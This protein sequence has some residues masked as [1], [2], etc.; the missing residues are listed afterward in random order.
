MNAHLDFRTANMTSKGQVLIPKDVR[1]RTGLVPGQ[2]VRVGVNEKG[3]AVVLPCADE[4]L[5]ERRERLLA[6]IDALTGTWKHLGTTEEI[7]L[8]LRGDEPFPP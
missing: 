6:S 7:M 3:E 2:P 8:D 4:S 5:A 1:D